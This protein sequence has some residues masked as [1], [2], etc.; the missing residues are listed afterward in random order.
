MDGVFDLLG[1][2]DPL[3]SDSGLLLAFTGD[4]FPEPA[5]VTVLLFTLFAFYY[6]YIST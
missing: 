5:G 4:G 2:F 1:N 6:N 3:F